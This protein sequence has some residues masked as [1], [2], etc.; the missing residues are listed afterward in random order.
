VTWN[1]TIPAN[2]TGRL[3]LGEE[4]AQTFQLDGQPLTRSSRVHALNADRGVE[5]ELP[6]GTYQFEVAMP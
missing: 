3:P 5:Y 1:L 4:Q 2:A 6:A